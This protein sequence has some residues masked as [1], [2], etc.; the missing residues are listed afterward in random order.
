MFNCLHTLFSQ[1]ATKRHSSCAE[2]VKVCQN[3]F[4]WWSNLLRCY[5]NCVKPLM[6]P[7]TRYQLE[8]YSPNFALEYQAEPDFSP[9]KL[10]WTLL[11]LIH[12]RAVI[13]E[14]I[15]TAQDELSV[16]GRLDVVRRNAIASCYFL[17]LYRQSCIRRF[18]TKSRPWD[19]LHWI[20][21]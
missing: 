1:I 19:Q 16:C 6:R 12:T 18:N 21:L 4:F 14:Q 5:A 15:C 3:D 20:V 17:T 7:H 13:T 8:L 10:D 11:S 9:K 2:C